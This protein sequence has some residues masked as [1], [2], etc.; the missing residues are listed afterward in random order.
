MTASS[1]CVIV[2]TYSSVGVP[3]YK[4]SKKMRKLVLFILTISLCTFTKS[5][6]QILKWEDC[7]KLL[8]QNNPQLKSSQHDVK[9]SEFGVTKARAGYFPDVTASGTLKRYEDTSISN[10]INES[11][12]YTGKATIEIFSGFE[13]FASIK[14]SQATLEKS[15][16]S[17]SQTKVSLLAELRHAF[18]QTLYAQENVKLS[19]KIEKRLKKNSNFLKLRYQGGLEAKWAFQKAEADWKESVWEHE[20]AQ[21][22]LKVARQKLNKVVGLQKSDDFSVSGDFSVPEVS[23][24]E[25]LKTNVLEKHPDIKYQ[26]FQK[27][28]SHATILKEISGFWPTVSLFADYSLKGV[29]N[30]PDKKAWSYGLEFSWALFS[31]LETYA[32]TRAARENYVKDDFTLQ[33]TVLTIDSEL[34]D[35]YTTYRYARNKVSITK[36]QLA[37]ARS[38]AAVVEEEYSSGLKT[39][40]DW[41]Q[42]QALLTQTEKQHLTSERDAVVSL[43]DFEKARGMEVPAP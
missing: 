33:D 14:E 28:L 42:S 10:K 13:T 38:R 29:N 43:A 24:L 20:K 12:T 31:G 26:Y 37:A 25:D 8:W 19:E 15:Q 11:Q 30:P 4:G 32:A 9:A 35:A 36:A 17:L 7:I 2:E 21:Q 39:F 40:L 41:E 22:E 1:L 5:S 27:E 34:K 3:A 23:T 18:A 16:A 6:A